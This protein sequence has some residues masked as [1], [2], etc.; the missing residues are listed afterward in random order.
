MRRSHFIVPKHIF[1]RPT[2]VFASGASVVPGW[3]SRPLF[4]RLLQMLYG[5]P[6]SYGWPRPDHAFLQRPPVMSS[7]LL[8]HLSHGRI[9]IRPP[10]G[11]VEPSGVCYTTGQQEAFDVIVYCTGYQERWPFMSEADLPPTGR[12]ALFLQLFHRRYDDLFVAGLLRTNGGGFSYFEKQG[13][14]IAMA[15]HAS[16]H[17][18]DA[19][20]MLKRRSGS[21]LRQTAQY[22]NNDYQ[23]D[24]LDGSEYLKQLDRLRRRLGWQH[25]TSVSA[26]LEVS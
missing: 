20:R 1:G 23:S 17:Q 7:Q 19:L 16:P 24:Y 25:P 13:A 26:G 10:V 6:E 4:K 3:I 11:S 2:D 15:H 14:M 9:K 22:Q 8:D 21:G 18:L 5:N 12:G